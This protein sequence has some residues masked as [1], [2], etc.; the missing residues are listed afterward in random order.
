MTYN[1]ALLEEFIIRRAISQVWGSWN[2]IHNL[3]RPADSLVAG[4]VRICNFQ[5]CA[6]AP[7]RYFRTRWG[8]S[9]DSHGTVRRT[10]RAVGWRARDTPISKLRS[11]P[12][13]MFAFPDFRLLADR[14]R[15]SDRKRVGGCENYRASRGVGRSLSA[16]PYAAQE[17]IPPCW[18]DLEEI[19]LWWAP[20]NILHRDRRR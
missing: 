14:R 10:A 16:R 4:G 18:S 17:R 1:I 6:D 20:R 8:G 3:R 15:L 9:G 7:C 2:S 11:A 12:L 5:K 19:R 13:P